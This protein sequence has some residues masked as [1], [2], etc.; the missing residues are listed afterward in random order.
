MKILFFILFSF[1]S[2]ANESM[3]IYHVSFFKG[4][5]DS[6]IK[7]EGRTFGSGSE[8]CRDI[9]KNKK[10]GFD[11]YHKI[12]RIIEKSSQYYKKGCKSSSYNKDCDID[13][14]VYKKYLISLIKQ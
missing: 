7:N 6:I 9:S 10:F 3:F 13:A 11:D 1:S 12:D 14:K 4:C 8:R 2:I 5:L